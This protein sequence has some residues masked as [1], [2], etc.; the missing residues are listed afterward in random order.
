MKGGIVDR[1]RS[2]PIV[3]WSVLAGHVGATLIRNLAA[4]GIMVAVALAIGLRPTAGIV[5]WVVVVGLLYGCSSAQTA[6][7]LMPDRGSGARGLMP[8]GGGAPLRLASRGHLRLSWLHGQG[9]ARV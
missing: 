1:F 7:R 5:E 2:L 8:G 4:S 3:G 6:M 9:R